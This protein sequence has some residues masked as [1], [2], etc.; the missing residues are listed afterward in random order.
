MMANDL[1]SNELQS[2]S[3]TAEEIESALKYWNTA[4]NETRET[5]EKEESPKLPVKDRRNILITSALPYV[6]NV[7]HLGNIIGSTLSAD[8]FARYCRLRNYNVIYICGTDE[9]GTATE[10]KAIQLGVTPQQICDKYHKIH[11]DVYEWF[12]IS[13]DKFGRTTTEQQTKIAQD[14]FWKVYNN[15]YC[16]EESVE[17]QFCEKCDRF[18]ADRLVEG[19]C[20]LC[21]Y[22]D[23]RGD[24][25]DK[26]GK[27]LDPMDLKNPR[28]KT[29]SNTPIVKSS[30]HLFLDLPKLQP[31][32]EEWFEK[33]CDSWTQTARVIAKAWLKEGLKPRCI[34]RDLKWGT[35]VP[36]EGYSD[37]VFY[38]WFDAPIGYLSISANYTED[39][40]KWWKNPSDVELYQFMAKDNVPFHSIIFPATELAT[41]E[42][43]TIVNHVIA[44][45]YL[46]YEDTKFS[47]SRSVGVFGDQAKDTKIASDIWRFYLLYIRPESQ[48]SSFNWSDFAGKN[49]SELLNNFGNFVNRALKFLKEQFNGTIPKIDLNDDDKQ[50]LVL[51]NRE[52]RS[53][54][55]LLEK[56]K[57]RDAIRHILN[58]SRLGNQYI[59][60]CKPWV[61]IKGSDAEKCRSGS[62]MA[63]S[64]NI[65]ALLSVLLL[66]Y[67]PDTCN[68][69]QNQLNICQTTL[70]IEGLRQYLKEGHKLGTNVTPLFQ[71][72]DQ[73][74]IEEFKQ[75][76]AGTQNAKDSNESKLPVTEEKCSLEELEAL[77]TEQGNKIRQLKLQASEKSVITGEVKI[78]N[79]LKQRLAVKK[80]EPI[81]TAKGKKGRK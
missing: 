19:T 13:F 64:A 37:K 16:L 24:Q 76:F 60:S 42:K 32:L 50:Y 62:V 61:L 45:E 57:L 39:W 66:P 71:S 51:I 70:D 56:V 15:G 52:I 7:P 80:G 41:K 63:F 65:A 1:K 2:P 8:V 73:K 29:C 79:D 28:C 17:Q 3:I 34:T 43:Y 9:Y 72:L 20:P 54:I 74:Q 11:A 23:A 75:R 31:Q 46:N 27:L 5:K 55:E 48:D 49:N 67:T 36:L 22:D 78:L 81:P 12:N 53:Y 33:N 10:T 18:L 6:N 21:N 35:P 77:V 25:C 14:I 68:N 38:V 69:L 4:I 26:C 44:V 40:E 47:K 30:K 59:Q 58:I